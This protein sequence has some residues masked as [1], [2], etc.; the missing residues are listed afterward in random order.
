M[1]TM[2]ILDTASN[3]TKA[4]GTLSAIAG[5]PTVLGAVSTGEWSAVAVGASV[6]GI[7]AVFAVVGLVKDKLRADQRDQIDELIKENREERKLRKAA[8]DLS[9]QWE[10]RFHRLERKVDELGGTPDPD[11]EVQP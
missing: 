10:R 8:E 4:T 11:S 9:D 2:Q 5:V 1:D 3:V 7:T 6:T